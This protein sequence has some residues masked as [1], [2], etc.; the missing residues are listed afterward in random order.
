MCCDRSSLRLQGDGWRIDVPL[1]CVRPGRIEVG[2]AGLREVLASAVEPLHIEVEPLSEVS[3][4]DGVFSDLEAMGRRN[5]G[6]GY[7]GRPGADPARIG[8]F[9][10]QAARVWRDAPWERVSERAL[11]C[12]RGLETSPVWVRVFGGMSGEGGALIYLTREGTQSLHLGPDALSGLPV[13]LLTFES[14]AGLGPRSRYEILRHGWCMEPMQGYPFLARTN[15]PP[16][17][18]SGEEMALACEVLQAACLFFGESA[19]RL[20]PSGRTVEVFW[21]RHAVGEPTPDGEVDDDIDDDWDGEDDD[22]WDGDFDDEDDDEA[23]RHPEAM[24]D[25][26][27]LGLLEDQ[28]GLSLDRDALAGGVSVERVLRRHGVEIDDEV[29]DYV[30]VLWERWWP[31]DPCVETRYDRASLPFFMAEE[32]GDVPRALWGFVA[33]MEASFLDPTRREALIES[34]GHEPAEHLF[35]ALALELFVD[36]PAEAAAHARLWVGAKAPWLRFKIVEA[37]SLLSQGKT[38][39][40]LRLFDQVTRGEP[41]S[42]VAHLAA[43]RAILD[44]A[45]SDK[46]LLRQAEWYL[47]RASQRLDE[48]EDIFRDGVQRALIELYERTGQAGKARELRA[49]LDG[50]A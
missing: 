34:M 48:F 8:E 19:E 13:L 2:D 7:V 18:A 47:E 14:L 41:H 28:Y 3:R 35:S 11:L 33:A 21:D 16:E 29:V 32:S 37:R 31:D 17:M 23:G 9:F 45:A 20:L 25:D 1:P 10:A 49:N 12:V 24:S 40:A 38:K 43:G 27:L 44:M 30:R 6:P 4:L 50:S 42:L 36:N 39:E 22:D 46:K 15:S 26:Q 5:M